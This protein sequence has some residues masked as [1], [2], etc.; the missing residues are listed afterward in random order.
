MTQLAVRV[1]PGVWRIPT[2]PLDLVNTFALVDDDG[3]VTLV[4]CGYRVWASRRINAALTSIGKH[5]RD[6]NRIV[7]T[8]AHGDHAGGARSVLRSSRAP[9][10]WVHEDDAPYVAAGREPSRDARFERPWARPLNNASATYPPVVV[11]DTFHDGQVL[12]V[13]G[14]LRVV[15]TPGHTPGHVALLHE[16]SGT[17]ITGDS[18]W[19]MRMRI[20]WPLNMFCFDAVRNQQTADVLGDLE[21]STAAFTHGPHIDERARESVREFLSTAKRLP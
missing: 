12:D 21:Y 10:V 17:L 3:S 7:L 16:T 20:Q 13:T 14:G 19:N 9:G 6:V 1:V 2:T 4:D 5:P 18:I 8:H 11:A 15:H